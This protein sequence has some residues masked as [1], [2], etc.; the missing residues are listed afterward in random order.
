LLV[1]GWGST[2][3]AITSA[4]ENVRAKGK[5]VSYVHLRHLWPFPAD[6][7]EILKRFE[8]VLVPEM[9]LGQL[10]LLLRGEYGLPVIGLSKV[11]GRPFKISEIQNKIEEL[12]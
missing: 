11:Q 2:Y 6:L 12:I 8:T 1:I 7:G 3:G 5:K 4:V 10:K 9:N